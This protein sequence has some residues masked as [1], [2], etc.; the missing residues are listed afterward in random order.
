MTFQK[1][2]VVAS[3]LDKAGVN[4]TTLLSQFREN[5]LV[6]TI[7]QNPGFDFYLPEKEIIF[8]ESLDLEKINQYDFIIFASKHRSESNEKTLSI[9]PV[10]NFRNAE[11]GGKSGKLS[12]TSAHFQKFMFEKLNEN[13][14]KYDLRDYKV[15]MECTHHG[16][17]I[18]KPCLFI[19]IGSTE[20]EWNDRRAAFIIAKTISESIQEFKEDEHNEVAIAIGG[21]HYCQSFN[22]I[23]LK[24]N[25]SISHIIPKYVLP[26]SREMIA[27]AID[28]TQEEIDFILL[29]W[30]GL[31]NAQH[32][33]QV[34]EILK[35]Y[36][37]SYRRTD[38]IGK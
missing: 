33:E 32:R 15:T 26:L 37:L 2:L 16:P 11:F 13:A 24:S 27:E 19:E 18:D 7:R 23:M 8:T 36:Y 17:L 31:G 12:K 6:S 5:P 20:I 34:L 14:A 21:L 28:K 25:I 3:K 29:D 22:K 4:I 38:E 10:G 35:S 9:H 1:F 30:K